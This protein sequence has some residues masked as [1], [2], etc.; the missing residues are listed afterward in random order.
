MPDI[1]RVSNLP[2]ISPSSIPDLECGRRYYQLRQLKVWPPRPMIEAVAFGIAVHEVLRLA[3]SNRTGGKPC[4]EH[5]EGWARTAVWRGRYPDGTDR[6]AATERVI[7]AVCA[8][9]QNDADDEEG[10]AGTIS[11]EKQDEFPRYYKGQPLF[12]VSAKIDR[13][14]SRASDSTRLVARNYKTSRPRLD[15]R[16]AFLELWLAK[17]LYPDFKSY[18]LEYIWLDPEDH[19]VSMDVVTEKDLRGIHDIVMQAAIK[20]LTDTDHKPCPGEC[21]TYCPIREG[22]EGQALI[23]SQ[24]QSGGGGK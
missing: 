1:A 16:Q 6:Q 21:C 13:I 2:R 15:L 12:L 10:V 9:I 3:F 18:V 17:R 24:T 19:R 22:C 4:L 14:F 20:V 11:I 7:A 8:F 5:V 23:S